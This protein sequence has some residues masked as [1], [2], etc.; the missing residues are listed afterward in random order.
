L[1]IFGV[2]STSFLKKDTPA[3]IFGAIGLGL[4]LLG[5][6]NRGITYPTELLGFSVTYASVG[7]IIGVII[8][9]LQSFFSRKE[10]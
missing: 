4:G 10:D 5:A 9:A 6:T 2:N 1:L 7:L 3:K 8:D